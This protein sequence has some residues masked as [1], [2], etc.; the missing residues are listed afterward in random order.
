MK[1]QMRKR[2]QIYKITEGNLNIN[3]NYTIIG[4][5]ISWHNVNNIFVCSTIMVFEISIFFDMIEYQSLFFIKSQKACEV[6]IILQDQLNMRVN[7]AMS[8][9][10]GD[11]ILQRLLQMTS[12]PTPTHSP[13]KAQTYSIEQWSNLENW[14]ITQ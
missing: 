13:W 9:Q 10:E 7:N 5:S 11:T 6:W 8:I 4:S 12:A 3:N 14:K 2:Q 1:C